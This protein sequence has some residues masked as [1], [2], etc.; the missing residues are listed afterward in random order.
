[1]TTS[2][3]FASKKWFISM[4]NNTIKLIKTYSV[5]KEWLIE[6][7]L[8][9]WAQQGRDMYGGFYE[10]L[11]L[12][13]QPDTDAIRRLR[14]QARQIYVYALASEQHWYPGH[15]IVTDVSEL[16]QKKGWGVDGQDG[17][18][19]L[20]YPDYSP[21][22]VRRDFYDHSFCLLAYGQ[23]YRLL[24]TP[25][26]N[27]RVEAVFNFLQTRMRA[28]TGGWHESLPISSGVRRQNP[29]M[30]FFESLL[31][32]Y[33]TGRQASYLEVMDEVFGLFR[34]YFYAPDYQCVYE[35]FDENFNVLY[36][37]IEAGHGAEWIWLLYQYQQLR[38]I[39]MQP[40]IDTLYGRLLNANSLLLNDVE[41]LEGQVVKPGKRLWVQTE[42]ARAQLVQVARGIAS[43]DQAANCLN[44]ISR[45]YLNDNG[46]WIDQLDVTDQPIAPRIPTSS[47][48]HIIN[49]IY[50]CGRVV[51]AL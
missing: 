34:D 5:L 49:M 28:M 3:A 46:T 23:A 31:L 22:D 18:V 47:F 27:T 44:E 35:Y 14:V 50:E 38:D 16:L 1:M 40:Y 36:P 26:I 11:Y 12:D 7:A 17:F 30:H 37:L 6:A 25:Q 19:H 20:W 29:H 8:P 15:D 32:L 48:Y 33:K 2:G 41:N 9:F 43:P 10:C 24:Q 13:G 42:W 45:L 21:Y 51:R 4:F 39:D